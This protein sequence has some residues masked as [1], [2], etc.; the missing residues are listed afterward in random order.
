MCGARGVCPF[1][2]GRRSLLDDDSLSQQ[3]R[4]LGVRSPVSRVS[5]PCKPPTGSPSS[6]SGCSCSRIRCRRRRRE[7]VVRQPVRNKVRARHTKRARGREERLIGPRTFS[8]TPPSSSS[9]ILVY[10]NFFC[11]L[12][13]SSASELVFSHL[14]ELP[15]R[16][17]ERARIFFF[18]KRERESE[19]ETE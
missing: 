11:L 16:E 13:S 6:A 15:K 18:S 19:R 1:T 4:S 17:R 10:T 14:G 2:V 3:L 7:R 8:A 12:S 9:S 5:R